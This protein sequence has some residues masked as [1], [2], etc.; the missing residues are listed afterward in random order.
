MST[1]R[2]PRVD[3][4]GLE[5]VGVQATGRGIPVDK[6]LSAGERLWAIGDVNGIWQLTHVGKYQGRV[7][8]ANMARRPPRSQLRGR[9]SSG[10]HRSAG[11]LGRRGRGL[12]QRSAPDAS[13]DL[14]GVHRLL[15]RRRIMSWPLAGLETSLA[16]RADCALSM[17]VL[18]ARR[19]V[20][21]LREA[22][23]TTRRT[24]TWGSERGTAG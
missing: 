5:T 21:T 23:R 2:R 7:V 1:G 15:D 22:E 24:R 13:F 12:L 10:L 20:S 3:G 19:R 8:A 11:C 9:A 6:R 16:K 14:D 17:I 4:L 18:L